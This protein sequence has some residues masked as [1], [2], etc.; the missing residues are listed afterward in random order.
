MYCSGHSSGTYLAVWSASSSGAAK[1]AR[2]GMFWPDASKHPVPVDSGLVTLQ[3]DIMN[4]DVPD[5]TVS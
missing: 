1:V 2:I 3:L 4:S 5:E